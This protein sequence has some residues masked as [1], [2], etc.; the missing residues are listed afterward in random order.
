MHTGE[1]LI[2]LAIAVALCALAI[3]GATSYLLTSL[4]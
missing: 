4:K 1:D 3:V 2:T